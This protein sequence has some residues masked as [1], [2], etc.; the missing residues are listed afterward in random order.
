MYL[1][2]K[3]HENTF[4]GIASISTT[5]NGTEQCPST[6]VIHH[7]SFTKAILHCTSTVKTTDIYV[8]TIQKHFSNDAC[9]EIN[10]KSVIFL[11]KKSH[12]M[13]TDFAFIFRYVDV[14]NVLV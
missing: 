1:V 4:N 5:I 14:S 7:S 11:E 10:M 6:Y 8:H 2:E 9:K 3:I 12:A 13:R